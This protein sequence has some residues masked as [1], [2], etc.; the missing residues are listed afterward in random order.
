MRVAQSTVCGL[1]LVLAASATV[2]LSAAV[3]D[4]LGKPVA[5]VRLVIDGHETTDQALTDVVETRVGRPLSMAEVRESIT[6]LFTLGRFENILVD[7]SLD[8]TGVAL[9]YELIPIHPVTKV[10]FEGGLDAPG[11]DQGRLRRAVFDRYGASPA[12]AR[13]EDVGRLVEGVLQESGY[14]HARVT[15]RSQLLHAPERATLVLGIEPGPRT[16]IGTIEVAGP[17]DTSSAELLA[18]LRLSPGA[19]YERAVLDARIERYL[20]QLRKRGYYEAKIVPTVHLADDDRIANLVLAATP[21][22]RVRVLF[23]GDALPAARREELVPIEREGSADEDVLEDA[24]NR[25][26]EYLRAEGFRDAEAPHTREEANGELMITFKIKKGH[27]YRVQRVEISGN[28]SIP[29]SELE[30]GFRLRDGQPFSLAKLDADVSAITGAYRRRGFAGVKVERAFEPVSTEAE[31]AAPQQSLLVTIAVTEGVRTLVGSVRIEGNQ[32]V[33]EATLAQGLGLV[34]GQPFTVAQLAADR[35]AIQVR[36]ANLGYRDARVDAVPRAVDGGTR[37]DIV[38]SVHEGSRVFVDHVLIIGNVRTSA[39]TIM[40][41]LQL[42]SGDPLGLSNVIQAKQ[43]LAALGLFRRTDIG[44]LRHGNETKRDLVVTVEEAPATTIGY[45]GG[46]EVRRRLVSEANNGGVATERLEFAPRASFQ[47]GRRNLFGKNRSVDFFASGSLHPTS[48][49]TVSSGQTPSV[50]TA[51]FT[52]Y[53]VIGT[54]REPRLLDTSADGFIT[55]TIEQQIRSSFNFS[56]RG[57]TAGIARRLAHNVSVT[58]SYQIQH[59][60]LFDER[61]TNSDQQLGANLLFGNALLSSFLSSVIRDTRDDPV[62]TRTGAYLS[63]NG[64][65]AGQ[66]IGSDVGFAKSYFTALLFR[67][68]PHANRLVLAGQARL[69]LATG[70]P[71]LVPKIVYVGEQPRTIMVINEDL[72][73]SER[74]FAGGD[75]TVRGFL[76]DRLGVQHT[77]PQPTDTIDNNGFPIGGNGLVILSA[78]LRAPVRWGL[79]VVGF[80]DGG[81]VFSRVHNI[82]LAELRGSVGF[83]LRYKSPI[84]PLRFDWG[85]KLHRDQIAA[86]VLEP[87]S[88]FW[89]SFGQAF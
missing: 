8:S 5:S 2:P 68:V 16:R 67:P 41:A 53:R 83:G 80:V 15:P 59:T 25:I 22:P 28:T 65:L 12:L 58:G 17:P 13:V 64:Q 35:D 55:A 46:G 30:P 74:F 72:P 9:R 82:D 50:N 49:S 3:A 77:P 45:G 66:A 89:I 42:K 57:A 1:V 31:A 38:F 56:R 33:Q 70:F 20:E 71:R 29:L 23:A 36:Y 81:N 73:L 37:A 18:Q 10:E 76:L 21:G 79:G 47:I 78:E 85:F 88:E 84:G 86:G 43:R 62:D 52:E 69:G 27:Q 40:G 26:E 61:F 54:F 63:A 48:S 14:L 24:S 75:T 44:E 87:R 51:G 60:K 11:V 34:A 19:P 7:A 32:S 6:H 4:Y 39:K